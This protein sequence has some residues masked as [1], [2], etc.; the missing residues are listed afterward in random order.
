[1]L[2]INKIRMRRTYPLPGFDTED[3]SIFFSFLLGVAID[4]V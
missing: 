4:G 3:V 1:M 2:Y